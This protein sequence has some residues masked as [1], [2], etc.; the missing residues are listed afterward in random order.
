MIYSKETYEQV[1]EEIKPILQSHYQEIAKHKDIPLEPDWEMY[2]AMQSLGIL[3]IFTVRTEP[4][5]EIGPGE[6]VGYGI[7]FVKKHLHYSSCLVANQD[8]LFMKKEYRGKGMRFINWCDEQLKAMGCH[9][10]IQ[11]V[12]AAHNF[13]PMLEKMNYELMDL[14]YTRRL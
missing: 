6:L 5:D 7:Y 11:H 1:I 13:G 9:M 4:D 10:T 12:K 14:I 3:K 8:I 2:K